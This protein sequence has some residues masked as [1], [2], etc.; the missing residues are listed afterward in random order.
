MALPSNTV[1][2]T[3]TIANVDINNNLTV[4]LPYTDTAGLAVA[5]GVA[6]VGF[7]AQINEGDS[8]TVTGIRDL[9]ATEVTSNYR[10][11]SGVDQTMFNENF[12]GSALNSTVW[13]APATT[14][15]VVVGSNVVAL[16]AAA[17]L[18]SGSVAR[19]ST[20]RSFPVLLTYP[21]Y[22]TSQVHF[23]ALPVAN[24]VHEWGLFIATGTAAPTDGA[25]FTVNAASEFRCVV[26]TN[27]TINQSPI[28]SFVNLIGVAQAHSF[29]IYAGQDIVAFWI[30]NVKVYQADLTSVATLGI[31]I[32]SGCLPASF[33]SYNSALVTGTASIMKVSA[34]N[35]TLAEMA[36]SK[37]WSNIQAGAGMSSY[38][39]QTGQTLGSTALYTNSLAAGAGAA[40]TNT[41]A[42]AGSGL[43]GQ[44]SYLPTL[45]VGTDGI[46]SS[47]QVPAG[48]ATATGRTL[49]IT[50]VSV[51][52]AVTTTLVGGPLVM[53]YSLAFGHNAVSLATTTTSAS[54]APVRIPIGIEAI[55]AAAAAGIT[56]SGVK[57]TFNSPVVVYPSEFIQV[58]AKNL[59]VV[60]TAG[61]VSAI[62]TFDGYWE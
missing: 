11:R 20:Y 2:L 43:G 42:A 35:V 6:V 46:L 12:T 25:Y 16:N 38:Q 32:G 60:T 17:S 49:Y 18:A 24:M 3:G 26:N 52:S 31:Q 50:G 7:A 23:T 62:I 9:K 47:Y 51:Q 59:G 36:N 61:V 41:T 37:P 8:G 22:T 1:G 28:L 55:V 48:T 21:L 45:A 53:A 29:L 40:L 39:G 57:Y 10:T 44:F 5:G 56:G 19:I 27:G 15:T 58:V 30:D 4:N 14:S 33:R 54:K 34:I 13:T